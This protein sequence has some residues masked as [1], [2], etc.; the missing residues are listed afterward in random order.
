M[1]PLWTALT[2]LFSASSVFAQDNLTITDAWTTPNLTKDGTVAVYMT[3]KNSGDK[4]AA[5]IGAHSPMANRVELH[6]SSTDAN[7]VMSMDSVLQAEVPA[8][9][10][11]YFKPNGLHVMA[12]G[13]KQKLEEG[14][15]LPITLE[16]RRHGAVAANAEV[17]PLATKAEPA[18][19]A[20]EE[21]PAEPKAEQE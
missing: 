16:F 20:A 1:K 19:K 7:G 15:S 17:R 18:E 21:T 6:N 14:K 12:F 2:L 9:G 13:L 10:N 8:H 11:L 5:I 4:P 3:V